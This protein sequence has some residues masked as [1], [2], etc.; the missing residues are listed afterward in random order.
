MF[1]KTINNAIPP[2]EAMKPGG[3]DDMKP[4]KNGENIPNAIQSRAKKIPLV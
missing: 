2:R 1:F 3:Q 4:V